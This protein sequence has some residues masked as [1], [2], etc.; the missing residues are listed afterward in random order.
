MAT[1]HWGNKDPMGIR[2]RIAVQLILLAIQ[3]LSPY[4]FK[5]EFKDDFNEIAELLT[6]KVRKK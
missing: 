5:H 3:I 4:Q 1:E 2:E 6:D